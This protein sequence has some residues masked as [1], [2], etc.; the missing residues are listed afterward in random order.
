MDER[1]GGGPLTG[2]C[3]LPR[4]LPLTARLPRM[5]RRCPAGAEPR[6][7]REPQAGSGQCAAAAGHSQTADVCRRG[8]AQGGGPAAREP[9]SPGQAATT[10]GDLFL[11]FSCTC[12][13]AV[14]IADAAPC[15]APATATGHRGAPVVIAGAA[16]HDTRRRGTGW[17]AG[18]SQTTRARVLVRVCGVWGR[19]RLFAAFLRQ[20]ATPADLAL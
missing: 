7:A 17:R 11:P 18:Q 13:A 2:T 4:F 6:G 9:C 12:D 10:G 8:A 5:R 20:V 1:G 3:T 16:A 15:R 14:R 19:H